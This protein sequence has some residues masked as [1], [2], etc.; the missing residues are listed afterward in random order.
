VDP[1]RQQKDPGLHVALPHEMLAPASATMPPLPLPELGTPLLLPVLLAEPLLPLEPPEP[2]PLLDAA[3]PLLVVPPLLEPLLPEAPPPSRESEPALSPQAAAHASH[4]TWSSSNDSRPPRALKT[5]G[6]L[7]L[8]GV[9]GRAL[10][11]ASPRTFTI[12]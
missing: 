10:H 8:G 4:A 9:P 7:L 2:L 3:L 1:V 11:Q 12:S 6:L 5:S